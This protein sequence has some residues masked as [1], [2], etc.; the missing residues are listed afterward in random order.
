MISKDI[1]K[2]LNELSDDLLIVNKLIVGA[3]LQFNNIKVKNNKL[4]LSCIEGNDVKT[5]NTFIKIIEL[6]NGKFDFEDVIHL[7]ETSIPSKDISVNGAVYTPNYIKD[8]IVQ[9]TLCK[10]EDSNLPSIKVSDIACGTGAFLYTVAQEI[11][12]KTNR[13]YFD[14]FKQNIYG[15]DISDYTITRAKILLSLLAISNGEDEEEF[16]F[17]LMV[18]NA[19]DFNWNKN[20]RVQRF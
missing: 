13:S 18:G 9:E 6:K 1:S 2:F 16:E 14:I 19:L 8:Y 3:Y 17:N 7:F 10:I 11:K 20:K 4:I 12:Q 5:I 15:L